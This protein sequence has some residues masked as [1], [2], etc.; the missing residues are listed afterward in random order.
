MPL[1]D[2]RCEKCKF[3][4]EKLVRK[5]GEKIL[6]PNCGKSDIAKIFTSAPKQL[7]F[8]LRKDKALHIGNREKK[9]PPGLKKVDLKD[10]KF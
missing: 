1:F 4:F 10:I 3:E 6:C 8:G 2:F 9:I 7:K 5:T